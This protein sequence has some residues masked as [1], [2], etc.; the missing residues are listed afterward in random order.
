M[1]SEIS[2]YNIRTFPRRTYR[3]FKW[4]WQRVWRG[5]DD[6]MVYSLDYWL[7]ETMPQMINEL[8]KHKGYPGMMLTDEIAKLPQDEI[9]KVCMSKWNSIL[10]DIVS[11]FEAAQQISDGGGAAWDEYFEEYHKL[12]GDSLDWCSNDYNKSRDEIWERLGMDA[13]LKKEE[14]ERYVI[15][16]KGMDLFKQYYFNLW[17]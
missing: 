11:G 10:N 2:L 8:R 14:E 9:D 3:R 17:W 12:Y 6:S 15:Y 1:L 4:A 13:R 16:N 5:W 7:S